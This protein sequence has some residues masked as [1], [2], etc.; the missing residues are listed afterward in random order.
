MINYLSIVRKA[1]QDAFAPAL[2]Q[3]LE[4]LVIDA[5]LL[6]NIFSTVEWCALFVD[7]QVARPSTT[8]HG[9]VLAI[10]RVSARLFRFRVTQINLERESTISY[11][12]CCQWT[13]INDLSTQCRKFFII[14]TTAAQLAIRVVG[15]VQTW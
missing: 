6:A 2:V 5:I 7:T 8:T 13:E 14:T 1:P 9:I 11:P 4:F 3:D 15:G 10:H 12:L